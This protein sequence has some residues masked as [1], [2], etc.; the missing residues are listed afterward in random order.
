[1][2]AK[3]IVTQRLYHTECKQFFG[4]II[5]QRNSHFTLLPAV[6]LVTPMIDNG[7]LPVAITVST[8]RYAWN[9]TKVRTQNRTRLGSGY[10]FVANTSSRSSRSCR[11][12][13]RLSLHCPL[14]R[15]RL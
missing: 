9:G 10:L 6:G 12:F 8:P 2:I 1:M 11:S 13:D 4:N 14:A 15:S 5:F 7:T 3:L